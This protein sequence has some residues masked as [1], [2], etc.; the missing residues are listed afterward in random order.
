VSTHAERDAAHEA[1]KRDV[2]RALE[3]RGFIVESTGFELLNLPQRIAARR[4]WPGELRRWWPDLRARR[5][6]FG[7]FWVDAKSDIR[8]DTENYS[9]ELAA[10]ACYGVLDARLRQ[11]VVL[12]WPSG[13][14]NY[15]THLTPV[16]VETR[17]GPNGSG[18]AFVLVRKSDQRSF[19]DIFGAL[20]EAKAA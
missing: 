7:C 1:H 19:D 18:T 15:S 2:V 10:L 9:V 3:A 13:A 4:A 5:G 11:T 17:G 20:E 16:H 6:P 14:C 12:V 8:A